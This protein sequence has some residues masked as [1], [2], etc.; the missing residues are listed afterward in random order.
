MLSKADELAIL[1][2]T[3]EKLGKHSYLGPALKELA[4]MIEDQ[5][6]SDFEPDVAGEIK[7][8]ERTKENLKGDIDRLNE[9]R[10]GLANDI[11]CKRGE[12]ARLDREIRETAS[13]AKD[14]AAD[15]RGIAQTAA[16]KAANG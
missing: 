16:S 1:N 4:P 7:R 10:H 11:L 2:E 13:R 6:R 3:I 12:L 14:L 15:L 8:L 5:I 9:E